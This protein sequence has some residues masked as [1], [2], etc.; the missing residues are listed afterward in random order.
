MF[1][2]GQ[3]NIKTKYQSLV[4]ALFVEQLKKDQIQKAFNFKILFIK[5]ATLV[6]QQ[7]LEMHIPSL[8][9]IFQ[10]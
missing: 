5:E 7:Y 6:L 2:E 3:N 9:E 1:Q 10:A 4:L 8:R